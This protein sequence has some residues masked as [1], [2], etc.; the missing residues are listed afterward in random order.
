MAPPPPPPPLPA[1]PLRDLPYCTCSGAFDYYSDPCFTNLDADKCPIAISAGTYCGGSSFGSWCNV[2]NAPCLKPYT[3]DLHYLTALVTSNWG[4]GTAT[5]NPHF[6]TAVE[7]LADLKSPLKSW[8]YC[9]PTEFRPSPSPPPR[10]PITEY[11]T[12]VN[13][14]IGGCA[15]SGGDA[16]QALVEESLEYEQCLERAGSEPDALGFSVWAVVPPSPPHS[17]PHSMA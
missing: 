16:P 6:S 11:G 3:A 15:D 9:R 12:I 1:P 5:A 4:L 8:M 2:D 7:Y 13:I 14:G 17:S 10:H